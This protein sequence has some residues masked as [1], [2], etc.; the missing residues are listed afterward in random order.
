MINKNILRSGKM[1]F[2]FFASKAIETASEKRFRAYLF[3]E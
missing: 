2:D 1:Y 3:Q